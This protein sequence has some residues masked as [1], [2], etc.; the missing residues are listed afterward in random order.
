MRDELKAEDGCM[1]HG[2]CTFVIG[3][4]VVALAN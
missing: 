1:R 3:G 2:L 4:R